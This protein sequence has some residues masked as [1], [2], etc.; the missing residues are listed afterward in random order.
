MGFVDLLKAHDNQ[1]RE[2]KDSK[3]EAAQLNEKVSST[4]MLVLVI[5]LMY[6]NW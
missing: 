4:Y 3:R 6:V 2:L 5:L 1:E